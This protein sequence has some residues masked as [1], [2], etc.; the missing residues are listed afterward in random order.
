MNLTDASNSRPHAVLTP[1]AARKLDARTPEIRFA[2]PRFRSRQRQRTR[3][4]LAVVAYALVAAALVLGTGLVPITS[5]S[6]TGVGLGLLAV[7]LVVLRARMTAARGVNTARTRDHLMAVGVGI[8]T[9]RV[10]ALLEEADVAPGAA[11]IIL[12]ESS[13]SLLAEEQEIRE[14]CQAK[15]ARLFVLLGPAE[16]GRESWLPERY[17]RA[18]YTL[19]DFAPDRADADGADLFVCA[20]RVASEGVCADAQAMGVGAGQLHTEVVRAGRSVR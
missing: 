8:G 3:T 1:D 18:G 11:T 17:V 14:L 16:P 15:G 10:R 12:R 20:P 5:A 13:A 7:A 9:M 19:A 4:L 2:P 6:V